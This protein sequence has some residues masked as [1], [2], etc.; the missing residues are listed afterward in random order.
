MD[1]DHGLT[2]RQIAMLAA[3]AGS[4]K[5]RL[6]VV[7]EAVFHD[8]AP[9]V[10]LEIRVVLQSGDKT[11]IRVRIRRD[12]LGAVSAAELES[13]T[14]RILSIIEHRNLETRRATDAA[15]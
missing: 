10:I 6:G 5:P 13:H 1:Q 8:D 7:D 14:H 2:A 3:T 15:G 12:W 4:W 9:D 11:P